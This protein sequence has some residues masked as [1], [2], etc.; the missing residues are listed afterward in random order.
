M[1]PKRRA[2]LAKKLGETTGEHILTGD[3]LTISLTSPENIDNLQNYFAAYINNLISSAKASE[4]T[5]EEFARLYLPNSDAIIEK[6]SLH[7]TSSVHTLINSQA[8][9]NGLVRLIYDQLTILLKSGIAEQHLA[10]FLDNNR[11]QLKN[12]INEQYV[13]DN[14]LNNETP[15]SEYLGSNIEKS[16]AALSALAAKHLPALLTQFLH[17]NK[18][19]DIQLEALTKQVL[20]D[21]LNPLARAFVNP[22]KVYNSIKANALSF[23]ADEAEVQKQIDV[24]IGK[25]SA[26]LNLPVSF[27]AEKLRTHAPL[28]QQHAGNLS[29][30]II[31]AILEKCATL[32]V[33]QLYDKHHDDILKYLNKCTEHLVPVLSSFITN[34][35]E[36]AKNRLLNER[37]STL[38]EKL[39]NNHILQLQAF[40]SNITTKSLVFAAPLVAKSLNISKLVEAQVNG[41]DIAKIESLTFDV[42]RRELGIIVALGGIL[43]FAVGIIVL[44]IQSIF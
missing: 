19:L 37:I 24:I 22:S 39:N 23:L 31:D 25:T 28:I 38:T 43:G 1:I 10:V 36:A 9:R 14:L 30:C 41:F 13:S 3:A 2:E 17:D 5:V 6:T 42:V 15:V 35:L 21:T 34:Y 33:S 44:L 4:L 11:E 32:T 8:F 7:I 20:D 12:F 29:D 16:Q 26:Q 40:V 27:Y 18:S